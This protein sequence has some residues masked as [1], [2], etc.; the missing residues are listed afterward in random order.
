MQKF[1]GKNRPSFNTYFHPLH[2]ST[3]LTGMEP[4]TLRLI[5]PKPKRY[6]T[7]PMCHISILYVY[8]AIGAKFFAIDYRQY[9]NENGRGDVRSGINDGAEHDRLV[10]ETRKRAGKRP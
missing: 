7:T 5:T 10:G 1:I 6:A 8:K 2:L 4:D 3:Y 9:G